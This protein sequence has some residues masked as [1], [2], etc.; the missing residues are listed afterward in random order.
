ML[1][2]EIIKEIMLILT[3]QGI[4]IDLGAVSKFLYC[5]NDIEI[6]QSIA[7]DLLEEE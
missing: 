5:I 2:E 6:L 3:N 1:K 7:K 4:Y